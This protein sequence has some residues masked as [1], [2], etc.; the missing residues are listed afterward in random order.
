MGRNVY[1][2]IE[3][4]DYKLE[5]VVDEYAESPREWDN[6]GEMI[7]FHRRYTLGDKHNYSEPRDFLA[8]KVW[9]LYRND[10]METTDDYSDEQ[11]VELI[12][13]RAFLLPLYLY[14]HSGI[15][16]STS[17]FS[18]RWDSGQV[19]WIYCSRER[20]EKEW[21][22]EGLFDEEWKQRVYEYLENEV[23]IY[24][25]FLT[26]DV[27]GYILYEKQ[28]AHEAGMALGV[29]WEES[30]GEWVDIESIW[31][32]FGTDWKKSGLWENL[33]LMARLDLEGK[34]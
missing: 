15:T 5:I 1:E 17:P 2:E 19:G 7:C 34:L 22:N 11:L 9:E 4:S 10:G 25:Q 24:D 27:Y 6:V 14:D 31:G 28:G 29:E 23:E 30:E 8:E 18:C 12:E 13:A 33:P 20:A 26:G 16:M 3:G 32:Y 21:H